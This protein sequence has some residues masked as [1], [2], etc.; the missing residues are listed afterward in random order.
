L[1][2]TASIKH[3]SANSNKEYS[4]LNKLKSELH[5]IYL[6]YKYGPRRFNEKKII[7]DLSFFSHIIFE[8]QNKNISLTFSKV[9]LT[10]DGRKEEIF[11]KNSRLD[12]E[13][14]IKTLLSL[15]RQIFFKQV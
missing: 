15:E 10:T 5:I 8:T 1:A 7:K 12:I 14:V 9:L 3:I 6:K 13:N 2:I 4:K 11:F